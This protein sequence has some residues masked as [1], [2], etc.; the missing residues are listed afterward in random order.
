MRRPPPPSTG[1]IRIGLHSVA[2]ELCLFRGCP[3]MT[4]DTRVTPREAL[5]EL[6]A[7]HLLDTHEEAVRTIGRLAEEADLL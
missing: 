1:E 5:D 3:W 4:P 7:R 6:I 2:A